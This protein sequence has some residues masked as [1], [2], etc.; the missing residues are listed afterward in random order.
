MIGFGV[1]GLRGKAKAILNWGNMHHTK[2]WWAYR[3]LPNIHFV[4][5]HDLKTNLVG[6]LH[7]LADFLGLPLTAAALPDIL[8]STTLEAMRA[9]AERLNPG[10]IDFWREGAKTFFY[11]GTNGRWQDVLSPE[12]VALYE[13]K[14]AQILTPFASTVFILWPVASMPFHF[15]VLH[16]AQGQYA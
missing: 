12:E 8:H 3:H 5:Y 7:R 4:H 14:A 2:T 13:E 16:F 6:E 11:K 9:R 10:M 1:A 15:L